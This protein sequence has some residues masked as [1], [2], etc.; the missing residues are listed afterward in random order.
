MRLTAATVVLAGIVVAVLCVGGCSGPGVTVQNVRGGT[1][2][3]TATDHVT[4]VLLVKSWF[5]IIYPKAADG[6]CG[7]DWDQEVLPDG[8]VHVWGTNSDCSTFDFVQAPDRSGSG[9][10]T[11]PDG[12]ISTMT[13]T[14]LSQ[15]GSS[16]TQGIQHALWDGTQL[17][18]TW[19]MDW[20]I[21]E[22]A[23]QTYEGS[24]TLADGRSMGFVLE[25]TTRAEDHLALALADGSQLEVQVPV[26]TVQTVPCPLFAEGAIG[27]F[28]SASGHELAFTLTGEQDR[29][30]RWQFTC[31]DGTW[32]DFAL[33]EDF[34][35][36]GQLT[37]GERLAGALRWLPTGDGTLDLVAAASAEVVPSAA[38]RDFQIEQWF[39]NLAAMGPTPM[40]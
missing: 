27:V 22:A 6:D 13:W 23:A 36:S 35:G 37:H 33:G 4:A 1:V 29:W 7:L 11:C 18:Y 28:R 30:D 39:A 19:T 40:Y 25:R 16:A 3:T 32:G 21:P 20:T 34:E 24:A 10:R 38:A 12:R 14:A 31:T 17:A 26:R 5:A 9:A 2:Q 15:D 8:S